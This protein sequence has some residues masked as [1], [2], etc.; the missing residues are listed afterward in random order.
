MDS[1]LQNLIK[2]YAPLSDFC[3]DPNYQFEEFKDRLFQPFSRQEKISRCCD[4]SKQTQVQKDLEDEYETV[5]QKVVKK[6]VQKKIGFVPQQQQQ[7]VY[8]S[9]YQTGKKSKM[10]QAAKRVMVYKKCRFK[11]SISIKTDWISI[12]ETQKQNI[13][14]VQYSMIDIKE[15]QSIGTIKKY[16]KEFDKVRPNYEKKISIIGG[17]VISGSVQDDKYFK[18]LIA[19]RQG[20]EEIPTIYTTDKLLFAVQTLKYSIYPWDILVTKKGNSYIF[21]KCPQNRSEL[22]YLELQTINE[23]I[24]VDMPEDEKT[25]R[26]YCEESTIAQLSWQLLSTLNQPVLFQNSLQNDEEAEQND[27]A[28]KYLFSDDLCFKYLEVSVKDRIDKAAKGE[29][30]R[31]GQERFKVVVRTTVEAENND[32][33]PVLVKSLNECET[34]P[35]WKKSLLSQAGITTNTAQVYNTNNIAKW[36]CQAQLLE[37]EEIKVG[38]LAR[39]NQKDQDKHSLL[40]VETFTQRDLAAIINFKSYEIW[41]S[42][43]YLV[44]YLKTQEDG[45]YVLL[46]QAYKQSVRIFNVR[47][48]DELQE[49]D[50]DSL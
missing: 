40:L 10:S 28:E 31:A 34:P 24:T 49:E 23:N 7:V 44:D 5:G 25:V 16:N 27:Q 39:Q 47:D 22:T 6:P 46:K 19:E 36:L 11:D 37:C 21:D 38:Y 1:D 13:E 3:P 2:N 14:K 41:Q 15:I 32:G 30:V 17:E 33:Q 8:Q 26:N 43:R 9:Y 29:D 20:T 42:V 18:Q 35:D 45:V 12:H 50:E 4:F 48:N